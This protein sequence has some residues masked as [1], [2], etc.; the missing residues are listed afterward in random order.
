VEF[1]PPPNAFT[2]RKTGRRMVLPLVQALADYLASLP[3]S[4]NPNA[5]IFPDAARAKRT[6]SLVES[7]P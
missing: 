1:S 6:A 2:T 7:I 3:A 4:D 5:F